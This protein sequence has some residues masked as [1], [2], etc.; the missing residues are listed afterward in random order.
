MKQKYILL[1]FISFFSCLIA[2]ENKKESFFL[3][4]GFGGAYGF[5]SDT[6]KRDYEVLEDKKLS[7]LNES[8]IPIRGFTYFTGRWPVSPNLS[9]GIQI[10]F[11][12]MQLDGFKTLFD[13]PVKGVLRMKIFDQLSFDG[14]FGYYPTLNDEF[15]GFELG[16]KGIYHG[17]FIGIS[18]VFG[19]DYTTPHLDIGFDISDILND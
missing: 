1:V 6:A 8:L 5:L 14:L 9:A 15:G 19:R 3:D 17:F 18:T 7:N 12:L 11:Y 4:V 10:G 13:F 16:F 2:E